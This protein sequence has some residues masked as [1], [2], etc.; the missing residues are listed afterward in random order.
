M[1]KHLLHGKLHFPSSLAFVREGRM[2]GCLFI[3]ESGLPFDGAPKGG[4]VSCITPG[5][6]REIVLRNL[7][8]PV[9]GLLWHQD[10]LIISEG[11]RPGRISRLFPDSGKLQVLQDNLPGHGNYQT[12]MAVAGPDGKLYFSQGALTNS[13]MIGHDSLQMAWLREI[14]HAA[15]IPGMEIVL[16]DVVRQA[17]DN[18]GRVWE[19]GAFSRLGERHAPGARLA[20]QLPCTSSVMRMNLDGSELELVAWGLRN[21]YGLLFLPDG[22][23]LA[24]DQ[25]ADVRGVRPV[26]GCPDFLYEVKAGAWYGFPDFYGGK[27]IS[28]YAAPDGTQQ[29]FLLANHAELP[30]PQTPLTAFEINAC[31]VKMAQIPAGLPYA[32]DL[33][34]AQFGDERPWTAPGAGQAGRNLVR[35]SLHDWQ[36]HSL[37][38]LGLQRPLD[39]AFG[40]DG[41]LYVVDFGEFEFRPD[42]SFAARAGSGAVWRIDPAFLEHSA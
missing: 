14:E 22:R 26:Y 42:F 37:P 11:G 5:G 28:A 2:A 9:N 35:V 41:L 3:A 15:D 17:R 33:L 32:G 23:L 24:T 20:A 8:E 16:R 18:Q 39:L 36:V 12:N 29:E 4:V 38:D 27:P 7:R 31:A 13:G 34:V 25:G 19:S 6:A 21:A 30:P 1:M 40:P 10:S